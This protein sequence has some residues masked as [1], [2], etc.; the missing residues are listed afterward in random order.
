MTL[1]FLSG[2]GADKRAFNFLTFPSNTKI[3]FIDWFTPK[4]QE[5]LQEYAKRIAQCIDTSSPFS[6]I[7]M[8]F[9]GILATEIL[10]YVQP[11]KTILISSASRRQE[12]PFYYRLAGFLKLDKLIP[13]KATNSANMLTYWMFGIQNSSDKTL[14]KDILKSTD[15]HFSKWAI[16]EILNWN[17]KTCQEHVIR[18]H[19][20]QDRILPI[21]NFK[22]KYLLK[23]AGHF[24]IV[25][26]AA[27]ISKIIAQEISFS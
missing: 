10:A 2:L 4:K 15:T 20:D 12:L 17:R 26:R 7:G 25:N 19:G 11:Y 9:G 3:V 24:M 5:S 22:P 6:I 27:E 16:S 8:S 23:H 21:L 13:G 18:I 14:L 1:Y